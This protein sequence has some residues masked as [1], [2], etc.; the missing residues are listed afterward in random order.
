MDTML[1]EL[2]HAIY[3]QHIDFNLPSPLVSPA[4]TFVTEAIAMFFGRLASDAQRIQD[5][6]HISD[7]EKEKISSVAKKTSRLKQLLFSRRAQVMYRF[8]KA[9]YNNPEQDL[10]TLWRDLVENY[11][12][13]VR[14]E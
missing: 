2:G 11:Q 13:L 8:E 6:L 10:D 14:P 4:H 3:D 7:E 12:G 9:L 1:H 5:M